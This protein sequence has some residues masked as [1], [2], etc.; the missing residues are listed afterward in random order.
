MPAQ[1]HPGFSSLPSLVWGDI[2]HI[3]RNNGGGASLM[4][5]T[6][7]DVYVGGKGHIISGDGTVH[8]DPVITLPRIVLGGVRLAPRSVGGFYVITNAGNDTCTLNVGC[9]GDIDRFYHYNSSTSAWERPAD[10]TPWI[11]VNTTDIIT[12]HEF[13]YIEIF[14]TG[15]GFAVHHI[16]SW[17]HTWHQ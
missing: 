5:L 11:P 3:S 2:S 16:F 14:D 1:Q 12:P 17:M 15:T 13:P 10:G 7:R 4:S 6:A 9:D 8:W